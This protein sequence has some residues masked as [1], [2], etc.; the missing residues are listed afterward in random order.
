MEEPTNPRGGGGGQSSYS[1]TGGS[2]DQAGTVVDDLDE[3]WPMRPSMA[4]AMLALVWM[5]NSASSSRFT[6]GLDGVE[7]SYRAYGHTKQRVAEAV[8]LS[9][10]TC[11]GDAGAGAAMSSFQLCNC[12]MNT[13]CL[14]CVFDLF[15]NNN[16]REIT[17]DKMVLALNSLGL[18][19]GHTGLTTTIGVYVHEG[20]VGLWFE[21]SAFLHHALDD[22]LDDVT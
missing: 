16:D 5:G 20:M 3:L 12:G 2:G 11:S 15:D 18:I 14:R 7:Y 17:M 19:A 8:N 9:L 1:A 10:P 4:A 6:S 21:D 22:A 13:V